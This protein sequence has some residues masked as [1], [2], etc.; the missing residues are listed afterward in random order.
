M[1]QCI[2]TNKKQSGQMTSYFL[3]N[4]K[5]LS[6]CLLQVTY[7]SLMMKYIRCTLYIVFLITWCLKIDGK[8]T[9]CL[10]IERAIDHLVYPYKQVL[11]MFN[12]LNFHALQVLLGTLLL[13]PRYKIIISSQSLCQNME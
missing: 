3:Y 5:K 12:L 4:L 10:I 11:I 2:S 8:L 6:P 13:V 7:S 9:R 1:T